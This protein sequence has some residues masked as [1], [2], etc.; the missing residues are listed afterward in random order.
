MRKQGIYIHIPFCAS[1]C[2]YCDFFSGGARGVDWK[3]LVDA[4]VNEMKERIK[5]LETPESCLSTLYIGG[6][7]PSLM[8]GDEFSRL[9]YGI[10]EITGKSGGWDEFTVEVNPED[11]S[12][13]ICDVLKSNGVNRVSM[14]VQSFS[15][16]ELAAI[17]RRHSAEKAKSSFQILR[18]YFD[19]ISIDLMFGLPGQNLESWENSI[20]EALKLHPEHISAYSL[21]FEEGTAMTVLRNQGRLEFPDEEECVDMW[22]ILS[23]K[24]D[25][26]GY[27]RYEIS[28]YS[29]PG[30][31]SIHNRRYWL[32]NPYL[33]IGPSA[34][35]YDGKR[36][37]KSNPLKIREYLEQYGDISG[38]HT[39]TDLLDFQDV[40]ILNDDELLEEH[41]MLRM[42]MREGIDLKE[43][44]EKFGEDIYKGLL[45]NAERVIKVGNVIIEDNHL[46]LTPEGVMKSDEIIISLMK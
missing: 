16:K 11:I 12:P 44:N 35:S 28:N 13:E 46:R 30:R 37:R 39:E 5:E 1:K 27:R 38:N 26:A 14:G 3:R 19:N 22:L 45:K 40:E 24:L 23:D 36:I 31:E 7:T 15:D 42:R 4:L 9:V 8:P 21:M 25:K 6:G 20:G 2:L 34:H 32:G 43:F 10:M 41:I 18:T 29:I 33:G 17:G